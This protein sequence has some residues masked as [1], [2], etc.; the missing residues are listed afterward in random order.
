MG[1]MSSNALSIYNRLFDN[2]IITIE[3]VTRRLE[4]SVAT[5]GRLLDR[6][7]EVGILNNL[8]NRKRNKI[9]IYKKYIE[10]FSED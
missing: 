5:S 4:I 1:R 3:E 9:F 2:P 10:I 8:G 6:L 7:C